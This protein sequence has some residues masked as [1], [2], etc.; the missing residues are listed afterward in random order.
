M[1]WEQGRSTIEDML[2]KGTLERVPPSADAARSLL[3]VA[4]RHLTSALAV[5][6]SDVVLAYDAL[7]GANRKAL[8][9]SS[10]RRG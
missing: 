1:P 7:H 10:S 9:R 3:E 8:R 4:Q 2:N 6:D 5:A